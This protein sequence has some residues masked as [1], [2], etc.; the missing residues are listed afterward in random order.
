VTGDKLIDPTPDEYPEMLDEFLHSYSRWLPLISA[1]PALD[2]VQMHADFYDAF[3]WLEEHRRHFWTVS[4]CQIV[5]SSRAR[6]AG[7]IDDGILDR[8]FGRPA[9]RRRPSTVL[10]QMLDAFWRSRMRHK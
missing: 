4:C 3:A 7:G 10:R 2:E 5:T 9:R 8:L 6:S 1:R